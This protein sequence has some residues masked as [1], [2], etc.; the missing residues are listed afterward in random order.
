MSLQNLQAQNVPQNYVALENNDG[1]LLYK[2]RVKQT[3]QSK[4]YKTKKLLLTR[5]FDK[6]L[7]SLDKEKLQK[8][9][10]PNSLKFREIMFV[11]LSITFNFKKLFRSRNHDHSF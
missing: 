3:Q 6:F 7:D 5:L 2:F 9:H 10:T 11:T 1:H 4:P 8:N